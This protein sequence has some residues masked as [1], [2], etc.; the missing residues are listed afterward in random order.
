MKKILILIAGLL[1][2][3]ACMRVSFAYDFLADESDTSDEPDS[4]VD[5]ES[6]GDELYIFDPDNETVNGTMY[7][8]GKRL[9]SDLFQLSISAKEM[10][11]PVLGIAF[12][13]SYDGQKLAF[14]KYDPGEFLERGGDPFYLVKNDETA[15][16]IILGETLRKDDSFPVGDGSVVTLYFQV[17]DGEQFDFKFKNGVVSTLDTVRQDIDKISWEDFSFGGSDESVVADGLG[18][19]S[20]LNSGG[21]SFSSI[22]VIITMIIA[23]IPASYGIILLIK[24]YSKLK[25]PSPI[26]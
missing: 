22:W 9:D 10:T 21:F 20:V 3:T 2:M 23:S 1:L 17:L 6:E 25:N 13:V 8:E 5:T 12:H 19:A 24:K 4:L 7:M 16:E 14:L 26:Y 18:N 15:M 11:T